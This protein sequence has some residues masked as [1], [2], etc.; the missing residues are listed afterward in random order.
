MGGDTSTG[1]KNSGEGSGG[2]KGSGGGKASGGA[3]GSGGASDTGG[4]KATGGAKTSGGSSNSGGMGGE[5]S[6]SGGED[7]GSGGET[8]GSGG[9]DAGS[10]G[11]T[12][13]S[14]GE[15]S[16]SGGETS[17][18]GGETSGSGGNN[19]T[20]GASSEPAA[21]ARSHQ[22]T[23]PQFGDIRGLS[24]GEGGK[25]YA[26][27]YIID[28]GDRYVA[29]ARILPD[30]SL[31]TSF[32]GDGIAAWNIVPRELEE[33]TVVNDGV[34][35]SYGV[36]ELE[37]GG[38]LVQFNARQ[39]DNTETW[40]G[41]LRVDSTGA[42]VESFGVDGVVHAR[43]ANDLDDES[44]RWGDT[45]WGF[46]LDTVSTPG[47]EKVVVFGH[48]GVVV[49]PSTSTSENDRIVT[50]LLVEDGSV[51]PEFNEGEAFRLNTAGTFSDGARRGLVLPDG[52]ILSSGYTNFAGG[53]GNNVVLIQLTADGALD[54]DFGFVTSPASDVVPATDGVAIFNPFAVDQGVSECYAAAVQ[55]SGRIVTTGYGRATG[56]GIPST[57]GYEISAAQ[58]AVNFGV[59]PE[60]LDATFGDDGQWAIQSEA[61]PGASLKEERGRDLVVLPDQRVVYAGRF[62]VGPALMIGRKNG[63]YDETVGDDL[64]GRFQYTSTTAGLNFYSVALS[65]DG[66]RVAA[67]TN[68]A[69]EGVLIAV[70]RVGDE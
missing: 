47:T 54:P 21:L 22:F 57:L 2:K 9:E 14:G 49:P 11:E 69:A 64:S 31:D 61:V 53:G 65:H 19:G 6:G 30:G 23:L 42:P 33:S 50:R 67:A 5:T 15:T 46:A 48:R 38:L 45:S 44:V 58:D 55:S 10:G 32:D 51:D 39:P 8:A 66:T 37:D 17:G 63:G 62:D 18:S 28:S 24:Y 56:T 34:E 16:G 3:Q 43:F 20:G 68:G 25:L 7:A 41:V 4:T 60:G 29:V 70:L 52:K 40:V 1:G 13:G 36:V 26:S 27:G 35:D 12:A 59:L